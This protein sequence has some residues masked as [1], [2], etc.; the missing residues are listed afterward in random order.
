[1]T[2]KLAED[3]RSNGRIH[4]LEEG[5]ETTLCGRNAEDFRI[6]K[7]NEFATCR[8]CADAAARLRKQERAS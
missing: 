2:L 8:A 1:M 4:I 3:F 5:S 6:R 7:D